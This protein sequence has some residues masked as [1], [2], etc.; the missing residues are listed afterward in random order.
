MLAAALRRGS[1]AHTASCLLGSGWWAQCAASGLPAA[2]APAAAR[3]AGQ[4]FSAAAA[5]PP[6]ADPTPQNYVMATATPVT[7]QLWQR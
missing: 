3:P 6:P 1:A 4:P 7:K 2:A 5:A